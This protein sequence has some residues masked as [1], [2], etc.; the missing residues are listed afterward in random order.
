MKEH[1]IE[2]EYMVPYTLRCITQCAA[3]WREIH[4]AI[5]GWNGG[6]ALEEFKTILLR[7]RLIKKPCDRKMKKQ[8]CACKICGEIGHTHEQHMDGNPHC[9]EHHPPEEC[10]TRKLLISYVKGLHTTRLSAK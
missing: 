7:S 6:N 8:T 10:P 4:P 9:E 5:Q 3:T 2:G 1:H